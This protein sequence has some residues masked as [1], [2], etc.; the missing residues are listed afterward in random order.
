MSNIEKTAQKIKE[1]DAILVSASNGL[2]ISEGFNIFANNHDFKKYFGTF[3]NKFGLSSILQGVSMQLPP[4]E[5]ARFMERLRQYM[6]DDYHGAPQF[7][8]LKQLIGSKDY[9]IITSNADTHFQLNGFAP[10]KI[11]EVEG[12]FF[13]LRMRSPEWE[14][15]KA[16]FQDFTERLRTKKVVQLELGIGAQNQLIKLPLMRMVAMNMSWTYLTLNLAQE[17]NILPVIADRS[18]PI[19]GD[20]TANLELLK[21]Q[22]ENE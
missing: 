4:A 12:N 15:Q 20:L 9:F 14:A 7:T 17:I 16:A 21:E 2:S 22:M 10:Q 1:A 5:H 19:A 13:G 18:V 8:N 11:W 6:V 3:Q